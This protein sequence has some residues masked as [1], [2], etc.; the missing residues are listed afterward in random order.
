MTI[1]YTT[2][3]K[4]YKPAEIMKMSPGMLRRELSALCAIEPEM[5]GKIEAEIGFTPIWTK[6]SAIQYAQ[7]ATAWAKLEDSNIGVF[8]QLLDL[9]LDY[10]RKAYA[11]FQDNGG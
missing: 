6:M 3:V 4:I 1:F 9:S 5:A 2:P 10:A 8:G 11:I 7:L